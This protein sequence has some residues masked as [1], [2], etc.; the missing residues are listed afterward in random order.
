MSFI[1]KW[2][3]NS[4]ARS[5]ARRDDRKDRKKN[6]QDFK[7]D[8]NDQNNYRKITNT[9]TRSLTK[10]TAYSNG[11]DPNMWIADTVGNVGDAVVGFVGAQGGGRFGASNTKLDTPVGAFEID[12]KSFGKDNFMLIAAALGLYLITKK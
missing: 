10:Q 4:A 11:I 12:S 6:R 2:F 8:K 5:D 9:G 1:N 3:D 7:L